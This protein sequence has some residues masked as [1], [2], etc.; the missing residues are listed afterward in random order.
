MNILMI[1][2]HGDQRMIKESL[3]LKKK[4]HRVSLLTRMNNSYIDYFDDY[5]VFESNEKLMAYLNYLEADIYHIHCKPAFIPKTAIEV[6][7]KRGKRFLYDVHDLDIVRFKKTN[8]EELYSLLNCPYLVFPDP[9]TEKEAKELILDHLSDPPKTMSLLPYFS[10]VDM[11]YPLIQPNP[12][13]VK[14]RIKK[15]V[16]EGNVIQPQIENIKLFPYYD[17]RFTGVTFIMYGY[18]FHLFGVGLPFDMVKQFYDGTGIH[19]HPPIEYQKL[20]REMS[21]FGWGFFGCFPRDVQANTTFANKVFDYICAGLP[22]AVMNAGRMA[23][24]LKTTGFGIDLKGF[25]DI[26]GMK[27]VEQWEKIQQNILVN[28]RQYSMEENIGP[29]EDFYK[30]ILEDKEFKGNHQE[31]RA[32]KETEGAKNI[33][34]EFTGICPG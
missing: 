22:V 12:H 11:I 5:I 1:C 32:E 20:V 4:G 13:A 34:H 8:N 24:W 9:G 28:R 33:V 15:I 25:D 10:E 31:V 14:E 21:V 29:L 7:K 18:E 17:L 3:A 26:E 6:L 16:Y 23:E 19:L 27:D 30:M 2:G